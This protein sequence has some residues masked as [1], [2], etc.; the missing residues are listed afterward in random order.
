MMRISVARATATAPSA[1]APTPRIVPVVLPHGGCGPDCPYCPDGASAVDTRLVPGTADVARA[2]HR[3][4]PR[5]A[6]GQRTLIAMYGGSI[7]SLPHPLRQALLDAGEREF[8]SSRVDG[9]RLSCDLRRLLRAPLGEWRVRGVRSIEVPLPSTHDAV[10]REWGAEDHPELAQRAVQ[11]ARWLG[12][13]IG[14]SLLPG[15]PGDSHERAV[16]SA[17]AVAEMAPDHVRILPAMAL[18]G[19]RL[20]RCWREGG[21]TPMSLEQA[22]ET[23]AEML[24]VFRGAGVPVIRIGLQPD[25]DLLRGPRVLAGPHHPSLRHRVES[26][27][28]RRLALDRARRQPFN[29]DLELRFHPADE[30]YL[31]G[32]GNG[33][34][35]ELRDRFRIQ[36]IAL[37]ADPAVSRGT[38]AWGSGT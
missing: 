10:L 18:E 5:P 13:E 6:P 17:V 7:A 30:S 37:R 24:Q 34:L 14:I 12:L 21:W 16:E 11:K 19:T 2:M 26:R 36:R 23:C 28:F 32:P 25:F 33:T 3:Y 29:A 27:L 15:L 1:A 31:R 20:E 8:R 9:L 22:E 35:H 4:A 38:I